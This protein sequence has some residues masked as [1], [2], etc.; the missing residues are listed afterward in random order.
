MNGLD[1]TANETFEAKDINLSIWTK[2]HNYVMG[3]KGRKD[4]LKDFCRK[5]GIKYPVVYGE[6]NHLPEYYMVENAEYTYLG[7]I[8]D[9][10]ILA[11]H[12]EYMN[13]QRLV[14]GLKLKIEAEVAK[15]EKAV[16]DEEKQL[17]GLK[18]DLANAKDAL[19]N[20]TFAGR[21][22]T[23]EAK[24]KNEEDRLRDCKRKLKSAE[25]KSEDNLKNWQKQVEIIKNTVGIQEQVLLVNI[26]KKIRKKLN[27]TEFKYNM[28]IYGKSVQ[29]IIDGD[30]HE[31][32]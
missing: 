23:Q 14:H 32:R 8:R 30:Y 27:F 6:N 31:G 7:K 9:K 22:A 13:K 3:R 4:T 26:T 19:S 1:V 29:E 20:I 11:F 21:I 17:A 18:K 10:I 28:P 16:Q 12:E 24:I 5:S 15:E 25:A 2:L